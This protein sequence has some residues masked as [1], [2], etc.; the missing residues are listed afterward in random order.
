MTRT[1]TQRRKEARRKEAVAEARASW[2]N[3]SQAHVCAVEN[4]AMFQVLYVNDAAYN[5]CKSLEGGLAGVP[6]RTNTV[7]KRYGAL[8]KRWSAY[9]A[10]IEKTG[11]DMNSV[12]N[13][14]SEM[15]GYMD[16]RVSDF[17]SAVR[18]VLE[19]EEVPYAGWIA[20]CE[21]A[22]TMCDYA[23]NM[24]R[25]LMKSLSQISPNARMLSLLIV[26]EPLKV[27]RSVTDAV[28]QIHVRKDIDL[29]KEKSVEAAFVRMNKAFCKP[30]NF[31][32]AQ[33]AADT[34]NAE[35]GRMKIM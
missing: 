32:G 9:N 35:E 26:E 2:E 24:C 33:T 28:Q 18:G 3:P 25:Q 20:S 30:E 10:L 13:L 23:V 12:A 22:L 14:F 15:D 11:I 1:K 34:L 27:M 16:A 5:C 21:T 7:S 19:R 31:I 17:Q 6:Y 29:T 4:Y 8:M